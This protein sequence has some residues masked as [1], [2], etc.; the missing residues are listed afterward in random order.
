MGVKEGQVIWLK[1]P[2][3]ITDEVS[4]IFHPYLVI[5][6]NKHGVKLVEVGQLDSENNRPWDVLRGRK[7]PIDNPNPVETVIYEVSY[8]QTDRKIQIEDFEELSEYLDTS[9][10]MSEKKFRKIVDSY[11]DKRNKYGSDNFRDMYLKKEDVLKYN[12]SVEWKE[13]QKRRFRKHGINKG[14]DRNEAGD[15]KR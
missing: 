12:S 3:G 13:A 8:L 7:I 15:V 9:D 4:K 10:V 5:G 6:I 2:F 11:Y 14:L 1:L